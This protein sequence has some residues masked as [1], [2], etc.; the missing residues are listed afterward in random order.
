MTSLRTSKTLSLCRGHSS[1]HSITG[2][3]ALQIRVDALAPGFS[4]QT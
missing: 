3:R 2:R 1:L 4:P